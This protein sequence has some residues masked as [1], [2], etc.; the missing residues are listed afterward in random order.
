[1]RSSRSARPN[2]VKWR[3]MSTRSALMQRLIRDL[4]LAG[5][6]LTALAVTAQAAQ[7]KLIG[8]PA[9]DFALRA[10]AGDNVRLSEAY[11]QPVV[12]VF[13]SSRCSPCARE[14]ARLARLYST[15]A[16]AGLKVFGV[17]V[18]DDPV[19]ARE[20]AHAHAMSYP[21]LLDDTKQA[22]RA[23]AIDT[24]PST[25]LIDRAGRVRYVHG[26][27]RADDSV[28]VSEIRV[29]LDDDFNAPVNGF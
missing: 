5:C 18:D 29:L 21:L 15:Y 27:E 22:A 24:L 13:W 14:L 10:V 16:S 12:L 4:W 28:Y 11:G 8:A 19:R 2:D 9:P 26:D 17:S 20:Y 25:V 7:P 6:A 1:M 23:Y 3:P